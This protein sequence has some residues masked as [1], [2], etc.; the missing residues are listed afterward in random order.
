M[1]N[2]EFQNY[3]APYLAAVSGRKAR[4]IVV[5]DVRGRTSIADAL[6]VCCGN[7]NRQVS[8][9]ADFVVRSL[10]DQ[11]IK[12]LSVEGLSE[13]RWV[14]L[15]YGGIIIHVFYESTRRFYDI[16]GLWSDA[17]RLDLSS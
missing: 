1:T 8:A 6:I 7:S 5:L 17:D 11:G 12:P 16:E 10:R 3:L 15:D 2:D 4:E 14:L 9:I 13:G